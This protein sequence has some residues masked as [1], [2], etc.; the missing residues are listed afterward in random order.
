M[1]E[2]KDRK[3]DLNLAQ[4]S[5]HNRGG[6]LQ[7]LALTATIGVELA[8]SVSL[9]YY[10]GQYLDQKMTTGPWFMLA[11]VLTG[12]AVGTVGVYKTLKGFLGE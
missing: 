5:K 4:N 11:G 1:A 12:L 7:A 10:G 9:G 6:A 8:L 2:K 3:K